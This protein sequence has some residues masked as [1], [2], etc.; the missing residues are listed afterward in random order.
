MGHSRRRYETADNR[1]TSRA[2]SLPLAQTLLH[3]GR[4]DHR[5]R[6]VI[7]ARAGTAVSDLTILTRFARL[8]IGIGQRNDAASVAESVRRVGRRRILLGAWLVVLVPHRQWRELGRLPRHRP[9][10]L[11]TAAP[12]GKAVPF[13]AS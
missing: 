11:C 4:A 6:R 9:S 7:P 2:K 12:N 3:Q 8:L 5:A 1:L 13:R 10:Q